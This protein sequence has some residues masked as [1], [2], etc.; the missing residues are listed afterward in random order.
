LLL[1]LLL[2]L[3]LL[4]CLLLLLLLL[5]HCFQASRQQAISA[6]AGAQR[7]LLLNCRCCSCVV[8]LLTCQLLHSHIRQGGQLLQFSA[9]ASP[10]SS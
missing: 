1:L 4:L 6:P 9:A 8:A 5:L 3:S 10:A 7:L 2:R